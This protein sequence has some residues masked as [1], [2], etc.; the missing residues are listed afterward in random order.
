[1]NIYPWKRFWCPRD[2]LFSLADGG[3]LYDPD[4]EYGELVNPDLASLAAFADCPCL[5]MLGEPGIGK[6]TEFEAEIRRVMETATAGEKTIR[7]DLREYQTDTR[8]VSDAFENDTIRDWAENDGILNLF[9]DSLDEGRL[10]IRNIA[11]LLAG[12]LRRLADHAGR[13]RL[14]IACRTAEWPASLESVLREIW[15]DGV[16][17]IK[18]APLRQLDVM[19]AA[20]A[21]GINAESFI[22]EIEQREAQPFAINPIT[23]EFLLDLFSQSSELPST[24]RDIYEAGCLKLC[25]ESSQSRHDAGHY[26]ILSAEQRLEIAS[27]IA[28]LLVFCGRSTIDTSVKLVSSPSSFT[29]ADLAGGWE[30]LGADRFDIS[31]DSI[32]EVLRT[33]LFSGRGPDQLGFAHRT[34]AEFLAARYVTRRG[35]DQR[36]IE[37]LIFH[38]EDETKIVPQLAETAAWIAVSNPSIFEKIMSGDPQVLLR[39]DVATA[40]DDVKEQ[41]VGK[42]VQ[43]FQSNE[44]DDS[45]W[46]LRDHY[47]KLSHAKLA[48]Q[49]GPVFL[50]K[51][52]NTV[53]RRFIADVAE[54]CQATRLLGALTTVAL[55]EED[56]P[57]IRAQAAHAIVKMGDEDSLNHLKPLAL[58]Q[59]GDDPDEELRGAA[60]RGLWRRRLITSEELF[61]SLIRPQRESF[62]GAYRMFLI[63]DLPENLKSRDLPTALRWCTEQEIERGTL[64]DFHDA[65]VAIVRQSL[66]HLDNQHILDAFCDYL[67]SRLIQHEDL[68][69]TTEEYASI[70]VSNRRMVIAAI[71][72][73]LENSNEHFLGLVWGK[74]SLTVP[75]DLEWMLEQSAAAGSVDEQQHWAD[76]A[77][78]RFERSDRS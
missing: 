2:K 60:L 56:D 68:A 54:E 46:D 64:D 57:Q 78:L 61:E 69:I 18:L 21:E 29:V 73:K 43:G 4:A 58:G 74:I 23:L 12:Q 63:Q 14:R 11:S 59:A 9:F 55:D 71:V 48:D 53:T 40:D 27:R 45:D 44:L 7:V 50:D 31:E 34:Y 66:S 38:V 28:A 42:L 15:R 25:S 22:E 52:Q 5:V 26:G 49:L 75:D 51:S 13:L 65:T 10:E 70:S 76:L 8:L 35:L 37:S 16:V 20:E 17:V 33:T 24:K 30:R 32:R 62:T 1:M 3:Y 67:V 72:P 39:S 77:R 19:S 6:S 47:E 41:L 36:Q